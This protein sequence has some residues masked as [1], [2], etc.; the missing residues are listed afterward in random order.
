[1][2]VPLGMLGRKHGLQLERTW[3][4]VEGKVDELDLSQGRGRGGL[5]G[6]GEQ[7]SSELQDSVAHDGSHPPHGAVGTKNVAGLN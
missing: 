7:N 5:A 1:M 4:R 3:H 6:K 2:Q